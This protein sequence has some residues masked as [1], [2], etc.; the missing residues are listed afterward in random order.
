MRQ[1]LAFLGLRAANGPGN[2]HVH[3]RYFNVL[4]GHHVTPG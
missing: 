3:S 4:L 2:L 1:D